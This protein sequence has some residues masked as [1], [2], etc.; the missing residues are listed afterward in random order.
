MSISK[1][2]RYARRISDNSYVV[3]LVHPSANRY[4]IDWF[5]T[6]NPAVKHLSI[7]DRI[8]FRSD[9]TVREFE[10]IF[11]KSEMKEVTK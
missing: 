9:W 3:A 7:A 1:S 2:K 10:N 8:D 6:N 11:L 5:V 4:Y